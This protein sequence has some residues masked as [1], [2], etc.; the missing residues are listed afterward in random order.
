MFYLTVY[1]AGK[2]WVDCVNKVLAICETLYQDVPQLT[3]LYDGHISA[4]S[5]VKYPD[6]Y[7]TSTA[8][9]KNL[10]NRLED[11]HFI[12]QNTA[13]LFGLEVCI[14][15]INI[16]ITDKCTFYISVSELRS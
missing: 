3:C 6:A 9:V 2:I 1:D 14:S 13:H 12:V 4:D 8:V 16:F 7:E 10:R 5:T 11:R 15:N